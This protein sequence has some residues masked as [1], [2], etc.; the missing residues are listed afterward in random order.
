MYKD[1]EIA[2]KPLNCLSE[3]DK[4][5]M[6]LCKAERISHKLQIMSFMGNFEESA[7]LLLPSLTTITA[8][9]R[10][11]KEAKKFHQLLELILAYGNYM[12]SGKRGG[13]FGF[14][15]QSLDTVCVG[16]LEVKN[17]Y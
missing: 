3:E 1:Y 5:M 8:A 7:N 16:F 9:S 14:K 6:Q 2:Q 17:T 4:F 10:S 11:V 13:V 15:L 12:N